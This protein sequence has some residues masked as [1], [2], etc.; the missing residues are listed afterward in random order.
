PSTSGTR[1]YVNDVG[2][3]TWEEIDELVAGAD[4]G[5][6]D[7]EGFC[8]N[9]STSNCGTVAGKRNPIYAYGRGDGC[10]SITGGA[11]VPNGIWPSEYDG[12]YLFGDYVCGRIYSLKN[13]VGTEFASN[14]G[15]VTTLEFGPYGSGQALYY[16]SFTGQI[17]RI[18]TNRA[19]VAV[20]TADKTSGLSPLQ[21]TFDGTQSTDP[22]NDALTYEWDFDDGD[23]S[24]S[25]KPTHTFT[26]AQPKTFVV[27]LTVRDNKGSSNS[28]T[29]S[30][31]VGNTAPVPTIVTP[32]TSDLFSVGQLIT[33]NGSAEDAQGDS[34][35]LKWDV[36]LHHDTHEHPFFSGTGASRTFNAPAPEDLLAATNS[37]LV[38]VLTATDS[39]G[40]SATVS[41][42][43]M[44][45][46]VQVTLDSAPSGLA[47]FVEGQ[48]ITTPTQITSWAGNPLDMSAPDQLLP[49]GDAVI[50]QGWSVSGG[51]S[52]QYATPAS[53][54][55]LTANYALQTGPAFAPVAD[56]RVRE[57]SPNANEGRVTGLTTKGG[58]TTDYESYL[59]FDVTGL[60]GDVVSAKI[61]F[62]AY[63]GTSNGPKIYKTSNSWSET[64]ITWANR[65]RSSGGAYADSLLIPDRT[66]FTLDVT[67]AI[68]GN[69]TFNFILRSTATDPVSVYSRES[70]NRQPRLVIV[71]EAGGSDTTA[72]GVPAGLT[73]TPLSS[74]AISL[75][76]DAAADNV[77][78]TGYDIFRDGKHLSSVAGTSFTDS[79]VGPSQRYGYQV[80]A[81]DAAGNRS[82]LSAVVNATTPPPTTTIVLTPSA[83][84][85]V[86]ESSPNSN[87]RSSSELRAEG[88]SDPDIES[89]LRFTLPPLSSDPYR[90][91]LRLFVPAKSGAGTNDAPAV[92]LIAS[93]WAESAVKW[94]NRPLRSGGKIADAGA[95][96]TGVWVEY[97]LTNV[98]LVCCTVNIGLYS[99]STDVVLFSSREGANPPQLVITTIGAIAASV[100]DEPATA[101]P[102]PTPTPTATATPA[103]SP[104]AELPFEDGF[105]S[106]DLSAWSGAEGFLTTDA[107]AR[108]GVRSG[109]ARSDGAPGS[110]GEPAFV[111]RTLSD[112]VPE[113]F[114][115]ADVFVDR[116]GD[117]VDLI[118][119]FDE[120]GRAL[121]T[122]FVTADG[123]L[124][125]R[126]ERTDAVFVATDLSSD[127]WH[128]IQL[129]VIGGRGGLVEI[130]LDDRL[131]A[132][133]EQALPNRPIGGIALGDSHTDR[134][135][136][137]AFDNARID[138]TCI[139]ECSTDLVTPEPEVTQVIPDATATETPRPEETPIPEPTATA[140][141]EPIPTETPTIPPVET[142]TPE[143]T[144]VPEENEPTPD[145]ES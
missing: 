30:S 64:G 40:L 98:L 137:V 41:Q 6:N 68:K 29:I 143:P 80:R 73:T 51:R 127:E 10:G 77:G 109:L 48:T 38:I 104:A 91:T 132:R 139:G 54:A 66:W 108:T 53:D 32:L 88:G 93:N 97:D 36:R 140:T 67:R 130:W 2:Q 17:R 144:P 58:T 5:W 19:P 31:D 78:V 89:Y 110:P 92:Y 1:I 122:V 62:Y 126:N 129:H 131:V 99:T 135:F 23:S 52:F 82:A 42:N 34:V 145:E 56:A 35:T 8:A 96:G 128:A 65:P 46:T 111:S 116:R 43:L 113:V 107:I 85:R 11:F 81:R 118:A 25:S 50:W 105:E 106:A 115:R 3:N 112:P 117:G 102:S 45:R 125:Y 120:R 86:S 18:S 100:P 101:E 16:G 44:P 79:S 114:V 28:T 133:A 39:H 22:D 71:T 70:S 136:T 4:Y 72:P 123:D 76:W 27:T 21:V 63:E 7:R 142:A 37:Y 14:I 9:G 138:R 124:A 33:L 47:I 84:A 75:R 103:P 141:P 20:A 60:T 24:T 61:Y 26:S 59:R 134:T 90:V 87:Y 74:D 55:T 13:G 12:A 95:V 69:G 57:G 94:N 121:I 15:G 83:D 49:S 119:V